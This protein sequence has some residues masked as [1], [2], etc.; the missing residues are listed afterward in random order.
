M[1]ISTVHRQPITDRSAWTGADLRADRSWEL[2]LDDADRQELTSALA[3]VNRQGLDLSRIGPDQ[4]PLPGLSRLL[5]A[6]GDELRV[7]RGFAEWDRL[8][9]Q[10][11]GETPTTGYDRLE[12]D[13][14]PGDVQFVNNYTVLHG[15]DAHADIPDEDDKRLLMRIWL[16]LN[17]SPRPLTDEAV[18]RYGIVRHGALGWTVDQCN[19]GAH[20]GP[21]PRTADGR[22]LVAGATR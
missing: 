21:H 8:E 11:D 9:E 12:V 15:R 17:G 19:A 18:V 14:Q 1:S 7:G 13:F 4:F 6:I 5:A 20:H 16:D 2:T 10:G 22:P 3:R